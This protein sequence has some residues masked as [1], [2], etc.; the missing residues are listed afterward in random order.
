MGGFAPWAGV[1]ILNYKGGEMK[2]E[3]EASKW[4][5]FPSYLSAFDYERD[6]TSSQAPSAVTSTTV[7]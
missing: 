2:F 6:V 3:Q 5:C 7:N 4:A 1:G